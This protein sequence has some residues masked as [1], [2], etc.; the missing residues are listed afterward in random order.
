MRQVKS[1]RKEKTCP[2]HSPRKN[3]TP[4]KE[5]EGFQGATGKPSG[6]SKQSLAEK[7]KLVQYIRHEKTQRQR[8]NP[9]GSK[10]RPES[11][12]VAASKVW[13]QRR[14]PSNFI[15]PCLFLSMREESLSPRLCERVLCNA[16]KR[17]ECAFLIAL[18]GFYPRP[19][20]GAAL[21]LRRASGPFETHFA[22]GLATFSGFFRVVIESVLAFLNYVPS[23]VLS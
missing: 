4:K 7:K 16:V 21:D 17:I 15:K 11:P 10:G 18:L 3:S 12:L 23:L 14:R 22:M 1:S 2:I 9:K 19:H 8:R 20:K 5:S 6:C 13:P